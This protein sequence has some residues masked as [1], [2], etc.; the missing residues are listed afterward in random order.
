MLV[1]PFIPNGREPKDR[2]TALWLKSE[3]SGLKNRHEPAP[4]AGRGEGCRGKVLKPMLKHVEA[5]VFI[6][7]SSQLLCSEFGCKMLEVC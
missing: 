6:D 2:P 1:I 4:Q 7:A 5:M 3:I